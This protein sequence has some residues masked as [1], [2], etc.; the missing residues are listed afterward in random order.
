MQCQQEVAGKHWASLAAETQEQMF[1]YVEEQK[2]FATLDQKFCQKMKQT[3]A[4]LSFE[5]PVSLDCNFNVQSGARSCGDADNY[6]AKCEKGEKEIPLLP[7]DEINGE[8][9]PNIVIIGMNYIRLCILFAFNLIF[10]HQF[11]Y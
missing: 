3:Y 11:L 6:D 4:P 5:K 10:Y 2:K 8:R 7:K 9:V 1:K